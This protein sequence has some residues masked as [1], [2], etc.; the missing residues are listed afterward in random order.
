MNL[1]KNWKS[2]GVLKFWVCE[3][4]VILHYKIGIARGMTHLVACSL[5]HSVN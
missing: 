3:K 2:Y 5:D 4:S 1:V